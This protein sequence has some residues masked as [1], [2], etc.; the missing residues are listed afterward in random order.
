MMHPSMQ[1][2]VHRRSGIDSSKCTGQ[3]SGGQVLS[4]DL[5]PV[6]AEIRRP[7]GY[8]MI[9]AK[10][11]IAKS[12]QDPRVAKKHEQFEKTGRVEGFDGE[13]INDY[14]TGRIEE[15]EFVPEG[16]PDIDKINVPLL[17]LTPA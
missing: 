15:H 5:L 17:G 16:E 13:K 11:I 4:E 6:I 8:S 2:D 3:K 7:Q 10:E 9:R 1:F 14:M 12:R